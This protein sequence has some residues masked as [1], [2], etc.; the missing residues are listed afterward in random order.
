MRTL[1]SLDATRSI[2]AYQFFDKLGRPT[3]SFLNEGGSPAVFITS[4]TQYDSL[5]RVWKVSNPYRT[6][7]STDPVNPS[8]NWTTTAYD[9]LGRVKTVTTPDGAQVVTTY[10]G[11]QVTV[12]DQAGKA[13]S[14]VTDVLGRLKQVTEAPAGLAYQTN[15]SYDVLGNLTTVAQDSPQASQRRYF[16]YDSLSRLIR[17][18]NPEQN[19]HASLALSDPISGNSQWSLG[20]TYDNNGNLAIKTDARGVTSAYTYDALNRNTIV[21]YSD[22]TPAIT[23]YYDGAVNGRG[24]F[25]YSFAGSSHT[26]NDS[27]DAMGRLLSVRQHFYANGGWGNGYVTSRTYNLAGGTTSQTT[28]RGESPAIPLTGRGALPASP[29]IWATG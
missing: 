24:R 28:R 20:Y 16:M 29:A 26:A 25:W 21:S 2:E 1:S 9:A 3:R 6:N 7:G 5:G 14:S 23:R 19:A 10:T 13:R 4:D 22:S 11:N 27:Y 18:K 12:Q 8:G 15:Y 17:A